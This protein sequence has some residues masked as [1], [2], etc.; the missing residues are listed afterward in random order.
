R[1]NALDD[2]AGGQSTL[3]WKL[4]RRLAL[5][6]RKE[7]QERR[8]TRVPYVVKGQRIHI[9]FPAENYRAAADEFTPN[10]YNATV[11]VALADQWEI[12]GSPGAIA[13]AA[14]VSA[15]WGRQARAELADVI[16]TY[17]DSKNDQW[18]TVVAASHD[19]VINNVDL[20][21]E[22]AK[23]P[24]TEKIKHLENS[25][26]GR[27][28]RERTIKS[29]NGVALIQA[30]NAGSTA[31]PALGAGAIPGAA[32]MAVFTSLASDMKNRK[33]GSIKGGTADE[34]AKY[35]TE[36]TRG[37][38]RRLGNDG[39]VVHWDLLSMMLDTWGEQALQAAGGS[40]AI[41]QN[42]VT[43][44]NGILEGVV[45]ELTKNNVIRM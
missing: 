41:P 16:A 43:A 37:T 40:A 27:N 17:A 13:A 1:I 28:S 19:Y 42:V 36:F 21:V 10:R 2:S 45:K 25:V 6:G 35:K 44:A 32:E 8:G 15:L 5:T 34:L 7:R 3:L 24:G 20:M 18:K 33:T 22:V 23:M 39:V 26:D 38:V 29:E 9:S 30:V 31:M 11:A 4:G 12:R 14:G